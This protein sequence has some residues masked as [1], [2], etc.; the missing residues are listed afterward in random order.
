MGLENE[1][2]LKRLITDRAI[3]IE[4]KHKPVVSVQNVC[5]LIMTS[6]DDWAVPVSL[7]ERRFCVLRVSDRKQGDHSYFQALRAEITNGGSAAFL[8]YLQQRSIA[9]WHPRSAVP[10]TEE[11]KNQ[12][13]ASLQ[14]CEALFKD[15][16]D[17]GI[18]PGT[19]EAK[20]DPLGQVTAKALMDHANSS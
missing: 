6:N 11:L 3:D 16:L 14:G 5:H 13:L 2:R 7:D 17:T 8:H 15:I 4:A 9:E 20:G 18:L 1:G 19:N 12:V 10:K